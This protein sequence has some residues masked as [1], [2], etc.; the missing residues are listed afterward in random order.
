MVTFL[1][2]LHLTVCIFLII[3]VLL[4]AGKGGGVFDPERVSW[5]TARK[6]GRVRSEPVMPSSR[7]MLLNL[8]SF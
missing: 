3:V 5:M 6:P 4:Q 7:R 1:T 8:C 2:V